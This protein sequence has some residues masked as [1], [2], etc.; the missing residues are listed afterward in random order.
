MGQSGNP[1]A[2]TYAYFGI[3]WYPVYGHSYKDTGFWIGVI[4]NSLVGHQELSIQ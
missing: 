2:K 4:I 3:T 1:N